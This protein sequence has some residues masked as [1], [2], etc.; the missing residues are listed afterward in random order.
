[1]H[2]YSPVAQTHIL[3]VL[4]DFQKKKFQINFANGSF[5]FSLLLSLSILLSY[6]AL[7]FV[8]PCYH[9]LEFVIF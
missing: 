1:M 9:D 2:T 7:I 8:V 5:W 4:L 6:L 3:L